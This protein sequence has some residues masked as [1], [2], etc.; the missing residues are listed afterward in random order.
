NLKALEKDVAVA[1]TRDDVSVVWPGRM[2]MGAHLIKARHALFSLKEPE[3]TN[4]DDNEGDAPVEENLRDPEADA[5]GECPEFVTA[6][7]TYTLENWP[8][9]SPAARVALEE[10]KDTH[11]LNVPPFYDMHFRI[12]S[13][14]EY[15]RHL[16][17]ALAE[18]SDLK[19]TIVADVCD[20]LVI[21]PRPPRVV[22]PRKSR[23]F[24]VHPSSPTKKAR[25]A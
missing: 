8:V 15:R 22:T 20:V 3:C 12:L 25:T 14:S 24:A 19:N 11:V 18:K 5:A 1:G 16:E 10:M 13:P 21:Y 23:I 17:G 6:L 9:S 2:V 4:A 7:A